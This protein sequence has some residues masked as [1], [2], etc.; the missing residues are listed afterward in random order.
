V[1]IATA[2]GSYRE[3]VLAK[4]LSELR[5]HRAFTA[6]GVLLLGI[7]IWALIRIWP[8][9]SSGQAMTIGFIWLGLTIVLEFV[10]EHLVWGCPR[11]E[12]LRGYSIVA[13]RVWVLVLIWITLAP[14]LLYQLL[15]WQYE[16]AGEGLEE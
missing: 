11:S 6:T 7:Y 13:R 9:N 12:L 1:P 10:F 8:S 2:N 14:Y 3:E 5:A 15:R 4:R 16:Q